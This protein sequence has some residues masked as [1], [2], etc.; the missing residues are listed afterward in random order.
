MLRLIYYIL[1]NFLKILINTWQ[2]DISILII[3]IRYLK[4]H[5][6]SSSHYVI[7]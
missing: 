1:I 6:T 3:Y 2:T 4:N 7:K 5:L